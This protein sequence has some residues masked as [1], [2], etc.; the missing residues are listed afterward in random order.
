[1]SRAG[2]C[3]SIKIYIVD[4]SS[5]GV[6]FILNT[7]IMKRKYSIGICIF[8]FISLIAFF[9]Y[10]FHPHYLLNSKNQTLS[11]KTLQTEQKKENFLDLIAGQNKAR[12]YF[13]QGETLY[14]ILDENKKSDIIEL[15]GTMYPS[16]GFFVTDIDGLRAG[17]GLN[18]I[19]YINNKEA[20]VGVSSYLPNN[21]DIINWKLEK[22]L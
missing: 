20:T 10:I 19:Y 2:S 13:T 15:N 22:N 21:G 6:F 14:Q 9:A 17:D 4:S 5:E 7:K 1:M 18:L 3:I 16:L 12:L 11:E 8:V